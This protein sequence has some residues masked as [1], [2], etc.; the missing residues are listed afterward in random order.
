[1]ACGYFLL[2]RNTK[3]LI[4]MATFLAAARQPKRTAEK[5][6]FGYFYHITLSPFFNLFRFKIR[7]SSHL[8][9]LC[10]R[11]GETY[12][13]VQLVFPCFAEVFFHLFHA[14]KSTSKILQCRR[15]K[16]PILLFANVLCRPRPRDPP[17]F[18]PGIKARPQAVLCRL[19]RLFRR[20]EKRLPG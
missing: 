20:K 18:Y 6:A 2:L 14:A 11:F 16:C 12:T 9:A 1:M 4:F 8:F 3:R 15:P 13:K 10:V 5:I 19:F 7:K 17:P